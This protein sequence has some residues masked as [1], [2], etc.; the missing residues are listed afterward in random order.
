M[1]QNSELELIAANFAP[2]DYFERDPEGNLAVRHM[3][4]PD[5]AYSYK[6]NE[7]DSDFLDE[8]G[9]LVEVP[10]PLIQGELESLDAYKLRL[11]L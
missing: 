9:N 6:K 5:P 7:D 2:N 8:N 4:T 1:S 11:S 10:Y 3:L